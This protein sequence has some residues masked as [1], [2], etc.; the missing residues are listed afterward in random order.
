MLPH[1]QR[2]NSREAYL[3]PSCK[4]RRQHVKAAPREIKSRLKQPLQSHWAETCRG[5]SAGETAPADSSVPG[6][7][8][9]RLRGRCPGSLPRSAAGTS[10]LYSS[11]GTEAFCPVDTT[12][13]DNLDERRRIR[14]ER[15]QVMLKQKSP[16]GTVGFKAGSV[17]TRNSV[18]WEPLS[19]NC[20]PW[21]PI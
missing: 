18:C 9:V 6:T 4:D 17:A 13:G 2:T 12:R 19:R 21:I 15:R 10:A 20:I 14:M 5:C 8:W 7:P 1:Q 11:P 16:L 3:F